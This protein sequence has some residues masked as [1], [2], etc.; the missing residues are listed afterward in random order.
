MS[1]EQLHTT[2]VD[3]LP[4]VNDDDVIVYTSERV[5]GD[6][7]M[8]GRVMFIGLRDD[9][10]FFVVENLMR[11]PGDAKR[12]FRV[13]VPGS[14]KRKAPEADTSDEPNVYEYFET[15]V[16]QEVPGTCVI[17]TVPTLC[18]PGMDDRA[19][20]KLVKDEIPSTVLR[21]GGKVIH[22]GYEMVPNSVLEMFKG[23]PC[24]AAWIKESLPSPVDEY[25]VFPSAPVAE[26]RNWHVFDPDDLESGI[27]AKMKHELFDLFCSPLAKVISINGTDTGGELRRSARANR[28]R[29]VT[30]NPWVASVAN[31]PL[32][33]ALIRGDMSGAHKLMTERHQRMYF[34]E[35]L[36]YVAEDLEQLRDLYMMNAT[37]GMFYLWLQHRKSIANDR[38]E[39]HNPDIVLRD[40]EDEDEEEAE[41]RDSGSDLEGFIVSD[42]EDDASVSEGEESGESQTDSESEEWSG[43]SGSEE[44]E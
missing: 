10:V 44:D 26:M 25:T 13:T 14:R 29:R 19:I 24:E 7:R 43:E 6:F 31:L 8:I 40:E 42:E 41:E 5:G 1:V 3:F 2:P 9:K 33:H 36:K 23:R 16:V 20:V 22:Y 38:Y 11:A 28:G 21:A 30:D 37:S 39:R 35:S 32:W 15:H 18:C 17:T 4:E 27:Y 34:K 12:D